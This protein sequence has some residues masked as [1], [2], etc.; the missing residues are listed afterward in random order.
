MEEGVRG[1]K[2][3]REG[4]GGRQGG[5]VERGERGRDRAMNRETERQGKGKGERGNPNFSETT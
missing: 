5:R 4:Q 3:G 2:E 1:P